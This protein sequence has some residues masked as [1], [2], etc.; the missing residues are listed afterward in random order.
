MSDGEKRRIRMRRPV[1]DNSDTLN[2]LRDELHSIA[3]A[4]IELAAKTAELS[5]R[6][7]ALFLDM[8]ESHIGLVDTELATAEVVTPVGRVVNVIDPKKFQEAVP[9]LQDFW[10]CVT[11]SI[12]KAKAVLGEREIERISTSTPGATKPPELVIK[13]KT[14]EPPSKSKR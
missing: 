7:R 4:R 13:L 9:S 1:G 3:N 6:E 8:K 5:G 2:R 10:D 12:T 11:V 14:A